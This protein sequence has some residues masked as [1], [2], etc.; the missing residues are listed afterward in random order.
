MVKANDYQPLALVQSAT[1]EPK[2]TLA[3]IEQLAKRYVETLPRHIDGEMI[4]FLAVSRFLVWL[5]QRE[6]QREVG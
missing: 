2:Y 5:K 4:P 3:E 6:Q 1:T